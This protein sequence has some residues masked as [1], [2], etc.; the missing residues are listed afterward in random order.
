[1]NIFKKYKTKTHQE[2]TTWLKQNKQNIS[3]FAHISFLLENIIRYGNFLHWQITYKQNYTM[4]PQDH[5][6]HCELWHKIAQAEK[7]ER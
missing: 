4:S 1:M 5:D 3:K 6:L 2:L 7:L